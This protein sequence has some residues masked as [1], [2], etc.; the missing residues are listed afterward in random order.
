VDD[1]SRLFRNLGDSMKFSERAKFIGIRVVYVSQGIDS[2]SEQSDTLMTVHGLVDQL[3][4]KEL[5]KKTHRGLEGRALLG[6]HTR[7][8]CFGY[9]NEVIPAGG[10]RL[11][12]NEEEAAIVSA[13][14]QA[15]RDMVPQRSQSHAAER[16]LRRQDHLEPI[17]IREAARNEQARRRARPR[18]EWLTM[19]KPDLRIVREALWNRVIDPVKIVGELFAKP[20]GGTKRTGGYLLSGFLKCGLCG[21]IETTSFAEIQKRVL[22]E[23]AIDYVLAEVG[24]RVREAKRNDRRPRQAAGGDRAGA[25]PPDYR[26]RRDRRL[27]RKLAAKGRDSFEEQIDELRQFVTSRLSTIR[28]LLAIDPARSRAKLAEHTQ[29]IKLVPGTDGNYGVQGTWSLFGRGT[30]FELVAGVCNAPNALV[31]PFRVALAEHA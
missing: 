27:T 29:E 12:V 25:R 11:V 1:T 22:G 2:G 19:D 6:Q 31:I 5:G 17:T 26:H 16:T 23:K 4:I 10:V 3:Y 28:E 8:R 18:N 7:G 21:A 9:K 13:C 15:H 20:G 14:R 24:K 30:D